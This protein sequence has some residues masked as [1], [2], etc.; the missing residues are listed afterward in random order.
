[1]TSPPNIEEVVERAVLAA[2]D[3]LLVS[4]EARAAIPS[5]K[6]RLELLHPLRLGIGSSFRLR[7]LNASRMASPAVEPW[8]LHEMPIS[9]FG[10]KGYVPAGWV[11]AK[12]ER[13]AVDVGEL[14]EAAVALLEEC[15]PNDGSIYAPTQYACDAV[16]RALERLTT[17]GD[18]R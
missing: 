4:G 6:K 13:P 3:W 5:T 7:G 10:G 16:R 1:M 15:D 17:M 9:F 8:M 18:N 2:Q 12:L 14:R 11:V